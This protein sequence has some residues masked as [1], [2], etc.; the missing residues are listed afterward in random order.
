MLVRR[1][2]EAGLCD[3][4]VGIESF[5]QRSLDVFEKSVSAERISECLT[6]LERHNLLGVTQG[7]IMFNPYGDFAG[8][9][10]TA[11]F[12]CR[13][14]LASFWNVSQKLQLF[15]GVRLI[16]RLR[17]DGLLTGYDEANKVYSYRF[18]DAR[19]DAAS[20]FLNM[21]NEPVI[22]RDNTLPRMLKSSVLKVLGELRRIGTVDPALESLRLAAN[23]ILQRNSKLN[24][25]YF[26]DVLAHFED[27]GKV[28]STAIHKRKTRY[29]DDLSD[30]LD[31]MQR[32]HDRGVAEIYD[33]VCSAVS[34]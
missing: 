3:V 25:E 6:L 23:N 32:L 20:R 21:N 5:D 30:C 15:P 19:M 33:T 26:L 27:G 2:R 8:L 22:V 12:L 28:D 9:R 4:F 10:T 29:L 18:L 24:T 34:A 14:N 17:A 13:Y 11:A 16:E 1:L 7:V 31:E